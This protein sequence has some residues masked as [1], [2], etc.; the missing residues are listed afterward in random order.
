MLLFVLS[1]FS[2]AA[3]TNTKNVLVVFSALVREH[4]A[5]DL[6]ES[7]VR[8]H[9]S[10]PVNFSVVY[11]DYQRLGQ[12]SYRESLATTFRLGYSEVKPDV[13]IKGEDWRGKTVD[14]Q[15]FVEAYGG[16]VVLAPLL[17]GHSTTATVARLRT[18][19]ASA[20]ATL[21]K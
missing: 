3:E 2:A 5:L 12:E 19:E 20:T 1:G 21:R 17:E 9:F 15:S 10:G 8:A 13:L 14:G 4:E 18:A 16:R 6:M 7:G 11:L